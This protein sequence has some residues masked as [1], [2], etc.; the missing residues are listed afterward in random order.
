MCIR[1]S[2]V[3]LGNVDIDNDSEAKYIHITK[4]TAKLVVNKNNNNS[5]N[6]NNNT[7]EL[8]SVQ[9]STVNQLINK[10][11]ATFETIILQRT[12]THIK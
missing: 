3:E 11:T 9:R 10:H 8:T 5:N 6:K 2:S 12:Y 7:D 1:D 4:P